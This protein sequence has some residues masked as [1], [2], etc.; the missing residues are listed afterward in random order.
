MNRYCPK[1]RTKRQR[2]CPS[3]IKFELQKGTSDRHLTHTLSLIF[4]GSSVS[5]TPVRL[6]YVALSKYHAWLNSLS[7][8]LLPFFQ[9][10]MM[11]GV[12]GLFPPPPLAVMERSRTTLGEMVE[13]IDLS[14][15]AWLASWCIPLQ[16][17][18]SWAQTYAKKLEGESRLGKAPNVISHWIESGGTAVGS[19]CTT[20]Q[21]GP[22]VSRV[23]LHHSRTSG[24]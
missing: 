5:S 9:S 3:T 17:G 15:R 16:G 13:P 1:D 8:L 11:A 4:T 19:A 18:S 7:L 10:Q 6:V 12:L 20:T 14:L 22:S 23:Q 24:G 21:A 2:A